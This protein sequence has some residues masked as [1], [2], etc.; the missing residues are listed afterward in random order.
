[1]ALLMRLGA[2]AWS[3]S[4]GAPFLAPENMRELCQCLLAAAAAKLLLEAAILSWLRATVF[5]PLRRTAILM[6]G[7]LA[8][9]T[10]IRFACGAM[11]GLA[12]PGLLLAWCSQAGEKS[13]LAVAAML[14]LMF[15]LNFA[16][17]LLERYLFFAAVVA[18]KMPGAPAA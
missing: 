3:A 16:G 11:G 1:V 18:P 15:S 8:R 14:V 4:G 9:V 10:A 5:T 13:A 7:D 17:E 2:A 12:L 6:T